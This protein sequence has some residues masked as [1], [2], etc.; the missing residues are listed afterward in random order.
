MTSN[1]AYRGKGSPFEVFEL[2][3]NNAFGFLDPIITKTFL[4][5][6]AAY[7][8]GDKVVLNNGT[9]GEVIYINPMHV[10]QPIVKVENEYMDLS[11]EKSIRV[12]E[13]L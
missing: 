6:M 11:V 5:N 2:M 12:A 10:S 7:Y 4:Q 1:R 8:I 3:Q 9:Q 13:L